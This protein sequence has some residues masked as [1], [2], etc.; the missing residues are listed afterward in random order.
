MAIVIAQRQ[1]IEERTQT[2]PAQDPSHDGG[3]NI[4]EDAIEAEPSA[5]LAPD[6]A[7]T[8]TGTVDYSASALFF[9]LFSS[10]GLP[11]FRGLLAAGG[12]IKKKITYSS[13]VIPYTTD[14]RADAATKNPQLRLM[15]RLAH[16]HLLRDDDD[17]G[18]AHAFLFHFAP[19]SSTASVTLAPRKPRL[20][21][22]RIVVV[23]RILA[24]D[25][26]CTFCVLL[27]FFSLSK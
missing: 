19:A 15:F 23:R 1:R 2:D 3:E 14:S 21:S 18:G 22:R 7:R 4:G 26:A 25:R 12:Y 17:N 24:I 10:E 5:D 20:A 13:A 16:F 6:V 9:F 11:Q 27:G 8:K